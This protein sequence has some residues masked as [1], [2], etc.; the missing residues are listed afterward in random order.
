MKSCL[1]FLLITESN[2]DPYYY[3]Q[4][5]SVTVTVTYLSLYHEDDEC[6]SS[7]LLVVL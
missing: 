1:K 5:Q 3:N 2:T 7:L 6:E 4:L